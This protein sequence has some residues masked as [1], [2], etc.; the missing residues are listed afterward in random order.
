MP[1]YEY[2]CRDCGHKLEIIQRLSD[3]PLKT[4]PTCSKDSL[5]KLVSAAGFQL[6]GTGWYET[7]FKNKGKPANKKADSDGGEGGE[8]SS[9]PEEKPAT[10]TE[11]T[12]APAAAPASTD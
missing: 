7:D 5:K 12:A 2:E 8:K 6:K 9:A 3:S 4:C 10:K 11:T 1:I